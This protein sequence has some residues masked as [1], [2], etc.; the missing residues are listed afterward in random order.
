MGRER[1]PLERRVVFIE[2]APRSGTTLLVSLLAAHSTVAGTVAE[3]HL[4]D[5]GLDALFDNHETGGADRSPF[6]SGYLDRAGLIAASRRFADDALLAL[7]E[8]VKPGAEFVVEKTPAPREGAER[9]LARKAEIYPDA[10]Y[11]HLVRDPEEVAASLARVP[12]AS[13]LSR[14]EALEWHRS[15]VAAIRSSFSALDYLELAY[16]DLSSDPVGAVGTVC[17]W[18]GIELTGPDRD[19]IA[20]LSRERISSVGPA[21]EQASRA[22]A[23]GGAVRRL[24]RRVAREEDPAVAPRP[25]SSLIGD[26]IAAARLGDER[27]L[28]DLTDPGFELIVR[29][30]E[31]DLLAGGD[32]ARSMLVLL[33]GESLGDRKLLENWAP[34]SGPGGDAVLVGSVDGEGRRTDACIAAAGDGSRVQRLLIISAGPLGGRVPTELDLP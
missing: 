14:A 3:S 16:E 34:A 29:S 20:T 33:A 11:L 28:G 2:G 5:R 15:A 31:G 1:S 30:G 4:F 7:R 25:E 6:L 32:E 23:A 27:R 8:A 21:S 9:T 18:L 13:Q 10:R 26:L 22:P 19:R 12:W 24:A 17:E